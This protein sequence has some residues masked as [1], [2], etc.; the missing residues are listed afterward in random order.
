MT[1]GFRQVDMCGCLWEREQA[2]GRGPR[3]G[4]GAS[5]G[6]R[7]SSRPELSAGCFQAGTWRQLGSEEAVGEPPLGREG[8][9]SW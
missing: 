5:V 2:N 8:F 4:T 1:E 7:A 6:S 9:H 3:V